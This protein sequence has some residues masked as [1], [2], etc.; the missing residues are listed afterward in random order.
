MANKKYKIKGNNKIPKYDSELEIEVDDQ[1]EAYSKPIPEEPTP[2]PG[3][4]GY[5]TWFNNF[6][7]KEKSNEKNADIAY[8][9]I[10]HPLPAKK[11]LFAY[12][13][14]TPHEIFPEDAGNGKIKFP[15]N[16]GDPP[17]GMGP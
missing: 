15:L 10:L 16:V 3:G 9:V 17:V 2:I 5:I 6:G 4:G 1:Y 8:T 12:Y 7:V 13:E 11:R 14:D